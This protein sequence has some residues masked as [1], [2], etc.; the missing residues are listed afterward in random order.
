M[1]SKFFSVILKLIKR[2]GL[3]PRLFFL[4]EG[5]FGHTTMPPSEILRLPKTTSNMEKM[6]GAPHAH[7]P[8]LLKAADCFA[9]ITL[10]PST[11]TTLVWMSRLGTQ[12]LW[13]H[14]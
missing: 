12:L 3:T 5:Q 6:K 10:C 1:L 4:K 14:L 2:L 11:T 13:S 8:Q 9:S 7:R